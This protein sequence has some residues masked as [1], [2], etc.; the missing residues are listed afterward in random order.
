MEILTLI[1]SFVLRL[2]KDNKKTDGEKIQQNV[3][4]ILIQN[5]KTR[6]PDNLTKEQRFALNS[7]RKKMGGLAV[8]LFDK[9]NRI[10]T[11]K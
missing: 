2:E 6:F 11:N 4:K 8:Y 7:L 10:C 9:R 3:S 5:L 1:E